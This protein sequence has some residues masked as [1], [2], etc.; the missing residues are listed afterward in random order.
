PVVPAAPVA[1]PLPLPPPRPAAP[2]APPAPVVPPVPAAPVV[3]PPLFGLQPIST[4]AARPR[5][6]AK[7]IRRMLSVPRAQDGAGKR[8][9][10]TV[11]CRRPARIG[12]PCGG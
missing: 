5:P 8:R 11:H 9:P 3:L 7:R 2:A 10:V 12:V 4:A 6:A 1:P